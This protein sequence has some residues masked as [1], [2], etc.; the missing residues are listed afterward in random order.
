SGRPPNAAPGSLGTVP[1]R[2]SKPRSDLDS[3]EESG[4]E[5]HRALA[6]RVQRHRGHEAQV[7]VSELVPLDGEIRADAGEDGEPT[8][9][10]PA[11]AESEAGDQGLAVR[12]LEDVGHQDLGLEE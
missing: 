5:A 8:G 3:G 4:P 11:E 12:A 9:E 1:A 10:I 7:L 2:R 6:P